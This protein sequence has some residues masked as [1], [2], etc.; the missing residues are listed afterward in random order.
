MGLINPAESL[1]TQRSNG[2]EWKAWYIELKSRY[3]KKNANAI[4]TKAWGLR[5][6][7]SA[8]TGDLDATLK[9]NGINLQRGALASLQEGA[10]SAMDTLE[11][12]FNMPK[13]ILIGGGI[14]VGV[15]LFIF[16]IQL[17]R[18]PERVGA[19]AGTAVKYAI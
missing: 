1:P 16:L 2:E 15:P 19:V 9:K 18:K 4:F 8:L 3:G 11:G 13:Y 14:L 5:G 10:Y 17:A 7:D 6:S 12:I